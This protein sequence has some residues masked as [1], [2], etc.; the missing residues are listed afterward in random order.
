MMINY[1]CTIPTKLMINSCLLESLIM[2]THIGQSSLTSS[3]TKHHF[4][5]LPKDIWRSESDRAITAIK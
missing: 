2:F 5:L 1:M 3:V 4:D